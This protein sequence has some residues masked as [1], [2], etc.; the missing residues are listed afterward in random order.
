VTTAQVVPPLLVFSDLDG[1][2]LDAEFSLAQAL[3]TVRR[4]VRS[5]V[6]VILCSAK[7]LAE[8]GPIRAELGLERFACVGENGSVVLW[9]DGTAARMEALGLPAR[10]IRDGL[11]RIGRRTGVTFTGYGSLGAD[12]VA[13]ITGLSPA[14]AQLAKSREFS[15]TLVDNHPL[16]VWRELEPEFRREGLVC[17]AGG[18]FHTVTGAGA[19]KGR[20]T[21]LVTARYEQAAGK[22]IPTVGI[23][24]S[25][26]DF[27]M[28]AAVSRAYLVQRPSGYWEELHLPGLIRWSGVG[29]IGFRTAVDQELA[30]LGSG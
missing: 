14:A 29:P 7:T 6:H 24:D 30:L 20:A 8:M 22:A 28:L 3:A 12:Q 17:S 27:P 2:L 1:T 5:G 23:G 4:A 13:A 9:P 19:D 25:A 11:D 18:R 26:N 15:E 16:D 10:D 21:R